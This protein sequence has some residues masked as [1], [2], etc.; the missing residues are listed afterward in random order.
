MSEI[1]IDADYPATSMDDGHII[2]LTGMVPATISYGPPGSYSTIHRNEIYNRSPALWRI[3]VDGYADPLKL[4]PGQ[5]AFVQMGNAGWFRSDQRRWVKKYPE[6]YCDP[7]GSDVAGDGL[8]PGAG[9]AFRNPQKAVSAA[10]YDVDSVG[11]TPKILLAD[12]AMF[13]PS[14][15]YAPFLVT[16]DGLGA[17]QVQVLGNVDAPANCIIARSTPGDIAYSKDKG[18]LLIKGV[19]LRPYVN[20]VTCLRSGHGGVIDQ[21]RNIFGHAPGGHHQVA[22]D[23]GVVNSNED[24]AIWGGGVTH[25]ASM[26]GGN[27]FAGGPPL[28]VTIANVPQFIYFGLASDARIW[29]SGVVSYIG[30]VA[31]NTRKFL[32]QESGGLI[33]NGTV[34]P[35]D[36]PGFANP[37]SFGWVR[38]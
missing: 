16:A 22:E 35:G 24:Y 27:I 4:Y 29:T 30:N 23:G 19:W 17:N 11:T 34:M 14:Y 33:L 25:M 1:V 38:H 12:N 20:N 37:A 28:V 13:G 3:A 10:L 9:R 7:F 8:G 32:T 18:I 31:A 15:E 21:G 5:S 2:N 36:V 6:F 26:N